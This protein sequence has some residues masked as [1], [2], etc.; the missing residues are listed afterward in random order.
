MDIH[1]IDP[2]KKRRICNSLLKD[3]QISDEYLNNVL[4]M[5]YNISKHI[6]KLYSNNQPNI[7]LGYLKSCLEYQSSNL[8]NNN[9]FIPTKS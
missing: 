3:A 6:N 7:N 8:G 2:I 5:Q 1:F 9:S 4:E